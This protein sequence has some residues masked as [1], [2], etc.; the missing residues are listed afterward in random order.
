MSVADPVFV[1]ILGSTKEIATISTTSQSVNWTGDAS[2]SQLGATLEIQNGSG[3]Q[4]FV[5][6]GVGAATATASSYPVAAGRL[7]RI[8]IP[9]GADTVAAIGAAAGTAV[10]FTRGVG[11]SAQ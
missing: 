3:Q 10:Y 5:A 7:A 8:A 9:P 2:S 4:I 6:W 1:P 11:G